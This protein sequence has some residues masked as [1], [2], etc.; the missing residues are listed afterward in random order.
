MLA[1]VPALTT[2]FVAFSTEV[3]DLT[4]QVGDPLG[5]LLEV[6]VGGGT[7]IAAGLRHARVA[8]H[9]ADPH[10]GRGGQ[11]LRGGVPAG[12]PARPRSGRWSSRAATVLG[13][14]SLDDAGRP[15]YSV[16]SPRQLV[17]AGM[18][19]AALSPLELA[20]WVGEQVRAMTGRAGPVT[21]PT[22]APVAG[23]RAST[24][25]RPGCASKVDDAVT[26]AAALAGDRARTAGHWSPSTTRPRSPW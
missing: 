23:G 9:R 11:R 16:R 6:Q 24:R 2:H 4:D 12:R 13:C 20:R 8:G 17:A 18:P 21:P 25:C 22:V 3:I 1:G 5:L 14:A 26:R 15:R 19:V 7:H 10:A